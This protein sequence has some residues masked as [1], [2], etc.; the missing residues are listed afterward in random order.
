MLS[1]LKIGT[2]CLGLGTLLALVGCQSNNSPT[3][4]MSNTAAR[5]DACKTTWVPM[6]T[7]D[8]YTPVGYR[9]TE[10]R[11]ECPDCKG[12]VSNFFATGNL[13]HHC[14][15]CGGNMTPCKGH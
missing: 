9:E 4:A 12:A 15:A 11:M 3:H 2:L 5:C 14:K 6:F 1:Q 7:T 10:E 8:G 13:E